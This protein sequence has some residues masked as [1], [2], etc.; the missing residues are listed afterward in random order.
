MASLMPTGDS[1]EA[2][3]LL[4]KLVELQNKVERIEGQALHVY[5][6][7]TCMFTDECSMCMAPVFSNFVAQHSILYRRDTGSDCGHAKSH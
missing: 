3:S 5:T 7:V 4:P 2:A 1:G 6:V